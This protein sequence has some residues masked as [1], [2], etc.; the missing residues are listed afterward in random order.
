MGA[1]AIKKIFPI[2]IAMMC[3]AG[4]LTGQLVFDHVSTKATQS[5]KE[6]S[7]IAHYESLFKNTKFISINEEEYE[8]SK[9]KA[10]IVI[11]NFW[12]SWCIPCLEEFPSLTSLRKKYKED[13]V[14]II[15]INSDQDMQ[16]QKIMKTKR[17]YSLNFP[18][19]EDK[20]GDILN[21]F[22][23]SAIPVSII[24]NRGKVVEISNGS[25]DFMS[26]KLINLIDQSLKK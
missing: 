12:A 11:L 16:R 13:Q 2:I 4:F 1:N 9:T 26:K 15:G 20:S 14:L 19:V 24:F 6:R 8:L 5:S 18:L 23:I 22:L 21:D 10:P 25:K 7:Q 17:K 3:L